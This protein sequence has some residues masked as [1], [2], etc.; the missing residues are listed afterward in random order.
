MA[1]LTRPGVEISQ[2][3]ITTSPTVA[4]PALVPCLVGPCYQ[5]VAP[6]DDVG[7]LNASAQVA[8]AAV[9]KSNVAIPGDQA[10]SG[11]IMSITVGLTDPQIIS[12]PTTVNAA[13]LSHALIVNT[14]NAQLENATAEIIEDLLVLKTMSVGGTARME[15]NAVAAP[16]QDAYTI[17]GTPAGTIATGQTNYAGFNYTIPYDSLPSPLAAIKEVTVGGADIK[18]YRFFNNTLTQFSTTSA[19]NWNGYSEIGRAHV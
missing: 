6:I 2:E 12:F 14:I 10:L 15:I 11:L 7:S 17:L 18:T 9:I 1:T 19:I 3:I 13:L 5:I 4:T 8:V 16:A